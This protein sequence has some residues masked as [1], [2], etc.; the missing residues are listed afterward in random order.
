[1]VLWA[2]LA[3]AAGSAPA[4]AQFPAVVE[5]GARV[6]VAVADS[7]R[8]FAFGPRAQLVHGTVVARAADTLYLAVPNAAG[9]LAVPRAS[10]RSLA[11]SRGVPSRTRSA[12]TQAAR[13]AALGALAFFAM[14]GVDGRDRPFR[15]PGQAT[16][17]G[18]A[19]GFGVGAVIGARSPVERW[20]AVRLGR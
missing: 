7:A 9:T 13:H 4:A 19:V 1:M 10:V 5:P 15:S 11:V 18:G 6:R 14:H 20:R 8:Q 17:V 3:L 2:T 16:L 12:F